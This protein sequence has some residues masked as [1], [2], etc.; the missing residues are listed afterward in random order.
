MAVYRCSRCD[1]FVDDDW[2]VGTEDPEDSCE[3]MCESCACEILDEDGNVIDEQ[4]LLDSDPDY[5]KWVSDR[6]RS[7]LAAFIEDYANE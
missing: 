1:R 6:Q 7:S 5:Q 2:E 4:K 3:M